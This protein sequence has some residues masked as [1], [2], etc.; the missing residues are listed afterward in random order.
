MSSTT[1]ATIARVHTPHS[2][3]SAKGIVTPVW[4]VLDYLHNHPFRLFQ[5]QLLFITKQRKM[6]LY[7]GSNDDDEIPPCSSCLLSFYHPPAPP[8]LYAMQSQC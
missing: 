8:S 7:G 1:I 3:Y 2:L 4:R 5:A 6:N